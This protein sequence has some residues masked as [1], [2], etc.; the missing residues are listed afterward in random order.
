MRFLWFLSIVLIFVLDFYYYENPF[1]WVMTA[2]LFLMP[3][4][5][6][7]TRLIAS[8]FVGVHFFSPDDF[9]REKEEFDVYIDFVNKTILPIP[10]IT[11][12]CKIRSAYSE[13]TQTASMSLA[14]KSE[15]RMIFRLK[16][17]HCSVVHIKIS[18]VFSSS[19]SK[20]FYKSINHKAE[21]LYIPVI[22]APSSAEG[23]VPEHTGNTERRI[24]EIIA[25]KRSQSGEFSD[26]RLFADGDRESRIHWKLSA[27]SEE[28]LVR[29]FSETIVPRVLL[30][31]NP[32][33]IE[34]TPPS[35]TD[36]VFA[37]ARRFS[38]ML[39][40]EGI[41]CAFLLSGY[42]AVPR[43]VSGIGEIEN[44]LAGMILLLFTKEESDK[45]TETY[46]FT[47]FDIVLVVGGSDKEVKRV[48]STE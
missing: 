2:A 18:G 45:I 40:G 33:D 42:D 41:P 48:A 38:L 23:Y 32:P 47:V 11:A 43:M 15:G 19:F 16:A 36:R 4:V 1:V 44:A 12:D 24:N 6:F 5:S 22:P 30:V 7:I 21:D 10:V 8:R 17:P 29:D 25:A 20:G 34:K 14:G 39:Y 3:L 35:V 37:D 28:L 13:E 9:T 31:I 46:N 27:K 26:L